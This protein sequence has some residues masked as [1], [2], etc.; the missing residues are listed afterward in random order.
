M[1]FN[2]NNY[3]FTIRY[4]IIPYFENNGINSAPTKNKSNNQ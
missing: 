2:F 1:N 4:V 3:I